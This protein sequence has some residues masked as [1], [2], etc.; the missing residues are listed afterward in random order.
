VT[1]GRDRRRN[2]GKET[3]GKR[4]RGEIEG[5]KSDL[6]DIRHRARHRV[7][8]RQEGETEE[9]RDSGREGGRQRGDKV[10]TEG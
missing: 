5:D 3:K 9:R 10:E 4:Q 8:K 1:E 2:G 7:V 6:S